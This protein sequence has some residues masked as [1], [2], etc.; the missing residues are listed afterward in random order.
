M[1]ICFGEH[2]LE[3]GVVEAEQALVEFTQVEEFARNDVIEVP[4]GAVVLKGHAGLQEHSQVSDELL[5]IAANERG[6][7][8]GVKAMFEELPNLAAEI[9]TAAFVILEIDRVF[10]FFDVFLGIGIFKQV[11]VASGFKGALEIVERRF[12]LV[13]FLPDGD[14]LFSVFC[15]KQFS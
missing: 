15:P 5:S 3:I 1:A 12:P 13:T 8:F 2:G 10:E 6:G 9:N 4:D 14:L 7:G 11:G